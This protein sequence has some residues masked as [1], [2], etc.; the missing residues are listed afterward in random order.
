MD[1]YINFSEEDGDIS[2]GEAYAALFVDA[3]MKGPA[4]EK[5]AL[6]WVYDEHGGWY[7]HVPP[8]RR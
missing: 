1:P 6:I 7:D 2:V 3:V 5:T 4:W 8:R